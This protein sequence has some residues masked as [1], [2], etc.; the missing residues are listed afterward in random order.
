[1]QETRRRI[2]DA[3]SDGPVSG[4]EMAEA[5]GVSRAAVWKH[6]EALREEGF[7]IESRSNG[8]VLS[9]GG[10]FGGASV[11]HGLSAPFEVEYHD[12]IANTNDR[13]REL[14]D[15]GESNIA[16][17]ADEQ[18]GA[19]G[20]LDRTWDAPSGGIYLSLVCRPDLPPAQAPIY[21]LAAAVA[22]A[23][24]LRGVGVDA[25]IKWP[26][27]VLVDGD[28]LCGILVEMQADA[29]SIDHAVV[30]IGLNANAAP[31]VP[32]ASPTSLAEHVGEVDRAGL[33]AGLLAEL[34][35]AYESGDGV[36]DE[37]RDRTS[38]LGRRVRVETPNETVEG[39]AERVDETGALVLSTDDGD[40]TVTAGDCVHLR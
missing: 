6:V 17:L 23:E 13:A 19:R 18:T 1:M 25:E 26:N 27:D 38:T 8:Y 35:D 3:L 29:E 9:G 37:W 40:R 16:V 32:D 10:D 22:T 34:E 11:E 7:G 21:T 15:A 5:L 12:S 4:P 2:L 28:K 33:T 14:A 30:G 20:R 39:V 36:L 31:D 24:A